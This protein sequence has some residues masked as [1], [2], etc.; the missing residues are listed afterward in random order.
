MCYQ[1]IHYPKLVSRGFVCGGHPPLG[2]AVAMAACDLQ[3]WVNSDF[4]NAESPVCWSLVHPEAEGHISQTVAV[5]DGD[6]KLVAT[7]TGGLVGS[8]PQR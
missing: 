8:P 6:D 2:I 1:V 4:D 5:I 3:V 7:M